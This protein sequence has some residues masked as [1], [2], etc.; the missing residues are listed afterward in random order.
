ME[1]KLDSPATCYF[2]I[3]NSISMKKITLN[4]FLVSAF[5]FFIIQSGAQVPASWQTRGVGG[6]G[7]LFFPRINPANDNEFYVAC[8]MS[9]MFH[10]TDFGATYT[11]VPFTKLQ[12][13]NMTTY[14]FTNNSSIAY[15]IANDGNINYGVRTTD[16]G[17]TWTA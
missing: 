14:E 12:V 9:E 16:G 11:Q 3:E 1:S 15:C 5:S 6:G 13:G 17:T 7:A 2:Y 4:L 10:S 8:D